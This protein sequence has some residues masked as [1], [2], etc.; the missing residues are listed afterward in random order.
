MPLLLLVWCFL[1]PFSPWLIAHSEPRQN[2]AK[3]TS[4]KNVPSAS[5]TLKSTT[6]MRL[7]H[8]SDKM[9][10]TIPEEVSLRMRPRQVDLADDDDASITS[11]ISLDFLAKDREDARTAGTQT[12]SSNGWS[13]DGSDYSLDVLLRKDEEEQSASESAKESL[14]TSDYSLNIRLSRSQHSLKA[15]QSSLG[16]VPQNLGA[17]HHSI[18]TF[19]TTR[20]TK[21]AET[22]LTTETTAVLPKTQTRKVSF[23]PRVRIMRVTNRKDL[24]KA[25][26]KRTWYSRDEFKDIR[27]ECFDTIKMMKEG[28]VNEEEGWC[29]LGLEYKTA[30]NYKARQRN[31][32]E[33]RQVVFEEQQFQRENEMPDPEWI[34][35]VSREQSRTCVEGALECARKV[36]QEAN[37]YLG[38]NDRYSNGSIFC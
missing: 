10:I 8:H 31:K 23:F 28:T 12:S 19:A 7:L 32:V 14:M 25:Q 16:A 37:E 24:L 1:S 22:D 26:I 2:N 33:V 17:S 6:T 29:S 15:S 35:R 21:S 30:Q 34:A 3:T 18:D 27:T 20:T 4:H 9:E 38:L 13:P 36:E 11:E 5:R